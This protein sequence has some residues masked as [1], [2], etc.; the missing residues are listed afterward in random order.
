[1]QNIIPSSGNRLHYVE[2]GSG[3]LVLLLHGFPESSY[4]WRHQMEPLANAGYR[5]VAP[6]L[7]GY[8]RSDRP[9][10]IS[11]YDI[12]HLVEDVV[13]LIH[14]LGERE[15]V[16]VGHDWGATVAW[17]A[18]LMHPEVVRAVA[19][20]SIPLRPRGP[21]PPLQAQRDAHGG[22]HYWNYIETPARADAE[23]GRDPE[24]SIRR[25]MV[26]LSGD[27][28]EVT[29]FILPEGGALLD[30]FPEPARLPTWLRGMDVE[31]YALDI[32]A[33]GFTG[34]LNYFRNMDRNW[35]LLAPFDG[36]Y[37][38]MP[39]LYIGGS[40]DPVVRAPGARESIDAMAG[41][42]PNFEP[43]IILPGCGH[44]TQQERPEQVNAALIQFLDRKASS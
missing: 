23:L 11:A 15:A 24:A 22:R 13:N 40:L 6:D 42:W 35:T 36:R 28:P 21:K 43:P 1:M 39:G 44:W 2:E 3:P 16:V 19:G 32:G 5:V 29:S 27:A 18:A 38:T 37:P 41:A 25:F 10:R 4:S 34:G 26:G 12:A 14:A 9:D 31:R 17:N 33:A 8:G 30:L 20:L 7:R